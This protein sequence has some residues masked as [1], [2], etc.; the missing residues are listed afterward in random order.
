MRRRS[1]FDERIALT[2]AAIDRIRALDGT[3]RALGATCGIDRATISS[4]CNHFRLLE[5]G[6]GRA[7]R[8]AAALELPFADVWQIVRL[9]DQ[10]AAPSVA[11]EHGVAGAGECPSR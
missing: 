1:T 7:V 11:E 6:D 2:P 4:L 10:P 8:L 9:G 5:I 3:Q